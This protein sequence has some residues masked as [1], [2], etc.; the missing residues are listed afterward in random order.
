[1]EAQL[2]LRNH[3]Y[4]RHIAVRVR[5]LAMC[6]ANSR[7]FISR[8]YHINCTSFIADDCYKGLRFQQ[9]YMPSDAKKRVSPMSH[10]L[11]LY[12]LIYQHAANYSTRSVPPDI[13]HQMFGDPPTSPDRNIGLKTPIIL[14]IQSTIRLKTYVIH[15]HAHSVHSIVQHICSLTCIHRTRHYTHPRWSLCRDKND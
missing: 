9:E 11:L 12:P 2:W 5:F 3:A 4:V 13:P 10:F 15:S 8:P 6:F 14:H 7:S 1:M